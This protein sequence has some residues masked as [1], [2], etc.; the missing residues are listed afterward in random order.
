MFAHTWMFA[1]YAH[2]L[3]GPGDATAVE[4]AGF[5]MISHETNRTRSTPITMSVRIEG[6]IF[7]SVPSVALRLSNAPITGWAFDLDGALKSTRI[8]EVTGAI[9][10]SGG[11]PTP[12]GCILART[13]TTTNKNPGGKSKC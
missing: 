11:S 5:D 7:S 10:K 13:P 6:C 1:G 12:T 4:V 3:T 8:G 2:E 9:K